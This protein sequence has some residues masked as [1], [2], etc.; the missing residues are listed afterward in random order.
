MKSFKNI[1]ITLG[2]LLL[3]S[4]AFAQAML[5]P[6]GDLVSAQALTSNRSFTLGPDLGTKRKLWEY[7]LV[8]I[9][10]EYTYSS[11]TD[12]Y[13]D[14]TASIDSGTTDLTIQDCTLANGRCESND[15]DWHKSVTASKNW[16]WRIDSRGFPEIECVISAT[17]AAAGDLVTVSAVGV[18]LL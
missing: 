1:L 8:L 17:G 4:N 11:A 9:S 15:A 2:L 3:S 16:I 14:C 10:I 12:I 6:F 18:P 7:G 5:Y 13:M